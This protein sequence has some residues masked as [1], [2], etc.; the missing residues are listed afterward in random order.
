MNSVQILI[1]RIEEN[2][3]YL[4]LIS[5]DDHPELAAELK[6]DIAQAKKALAH[7]DVFV[8]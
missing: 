2:R 5:A 4:E 7:V 3:N 1:K 8:A 6:A